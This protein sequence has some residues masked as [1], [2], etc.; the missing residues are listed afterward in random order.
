MIRPSVHLA[1]IQMVSVHLAEIQV[2]SVHQCN[3]N[4]GPRTPRGPR[5]AP[6][7][8]RGDMAIVLVLAILG[9]ISIGNRLTAQQYTVACIQ[10]GK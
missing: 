4:C 3:S 9:S 7:G 1:D 2:V 10:L 6:G 8:P 5:D